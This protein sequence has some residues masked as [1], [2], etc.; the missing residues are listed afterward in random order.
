M[1]FEID[2]KKEVTKFQQSIGNRVMNLKLVFEQ[3][4]TD[5]NMWRFFAF[6]RFAEELKL[7]EEEWAELYLFLS[8]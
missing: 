2:W 8:E 5:A 7:T 3:V 1:K 6:I 4:E